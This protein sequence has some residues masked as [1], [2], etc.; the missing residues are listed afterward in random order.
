M[1]PYVS[2]LDTE[3]LVT[4]YRHPDRETG[5]ACSNCDRPICADCLR[6]SPVGQRCP[7]CA[8]E[9]QRT[10]RPRTMSR[11]RPAVTTV[12]IVVNVLVYLMVNM[13][14]SQLTLSDG[15]LRA[16]DVAAGDWYRI[17][18]SAFLHG[19]LLHLAF[20]MYALYLFGGILEQRFGALRYGMVYAVGGLFGAAGALLL[21]SPNTLTVGA[22]GAIFAVLGAMFLVEQRHGVAPLAGVGGLIA[23]NLFITF[24]VPGISI[25]GHLGGLFGGAAVAWVIESTGYARRVPSAATLAGVAA[26]T[27][28]ALAL[29]VSAV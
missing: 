17:V 19:G 25:G 12:L 8:S 28:V 5:L 22:S 26:L 29:I 4:C 11:S 27:V 1:I 13:R 9:Q 23:I 24:L 10:L 15:G 20:N 3:P 14:M 16:T 7:E 18:T 21:S 6:Q 2:T